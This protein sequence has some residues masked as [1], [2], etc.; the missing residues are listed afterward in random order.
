MESASPKRRR[1]VSFPSKESA[2]EGSCHFSTVLSKSQASFG[3]GGPRGQ[4]MRSAEGRKARLVKQ[5]KRGKKGG[6]RKRKRRGKG[7]GNDRTF[8]M[9]PRRARRGSAI[10]CVLGHRVRH[11][12]FQ[13]RGLASIACTRSYASMIRG[14]QPRTSD[15]L[16]K[17]N[18]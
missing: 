10:E 18:I 17:E 6:T 14:K 9:R 5:C 1:L 13:L 12:S 7:E 16:R 8:C 3:A 11:P 2:S 4:S 15:Q